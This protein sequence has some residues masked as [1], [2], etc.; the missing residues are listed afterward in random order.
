MD[1]FESCKGF[2]VPLDT[3]SKDMLLV[4]WDYLSYAEFESYL[5]SDSISF[6]AYL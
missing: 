2:K 4:K 6:S 1:D 5:H 3:L